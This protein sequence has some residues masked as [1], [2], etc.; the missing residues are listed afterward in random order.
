[1]CLSTI[2]TFSAHRSHINRRS[3]V[4]NLLCIAGRLNCLIRVGASCRLPGICQGILL[5][6]V[7]DQLVCQSIKAEVKCVCNAGDKLSTSRHHRFLPFQPKNLPVPTSSSQSDIWM[8][9]LELDAT[10]GKQMMVPD[11][12]GRS[13]WQYCRLLVLSR[14]TIIV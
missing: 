4:F 1:M 8:M 3:L 10:L 5:Q 13:F 12:T 14:H 9:D 6:C 11:V 7:L 2:L